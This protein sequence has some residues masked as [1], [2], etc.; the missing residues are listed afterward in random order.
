MLFPRW[1]CWRNTHTYSHAIALL[2]RNVS[3]RSPLS[4]PPPRTPTPAVYF[5]T[6]LCTNPCNPPKPSHAQA[7][8]HGLSYMVD[9]LVEDVEGLLAEPLEAANINS[10][11]LQYIMS[12]GQGPLEAA[13]S[14]LHGDTVTHVDSY[15]KVRGTSLALCVCV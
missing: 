12:I 6:L 10:T 2:T 11:R 7:T 4:L 9:R 13:L 8:V 1:A 3:T 5:A 14:V 15:Y